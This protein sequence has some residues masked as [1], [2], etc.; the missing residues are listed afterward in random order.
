MALRLRSAGA[1][2]TGMTREAGVLYCKE[3]VLPMRIV[4]CDDDSVLLR[5]L[6]TYVREFFSAL[7]GPEPEYVS[8]PSGDELMRQ[9]SSF[10]IAFWTW[11]CRARAG[12]AALFA[13]S[14]LNHSSLNTLAFCSVYFRLLRLNAPFVW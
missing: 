11:R 12:Y 10:D 7:G 1:G 5:Q 8:Y 3:E 9:A 6:Q 14:L 4:F 13:V 2:N